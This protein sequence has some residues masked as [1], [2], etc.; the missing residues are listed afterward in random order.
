MDPFLLKMGK[1]A[2]AQNRVVEYLSW[3]PQL[4]WVATIPEGKRN[5]AAQKAWKLLGGKKYTPD[6]ILYEPR[7]GFCGLAIEL[8]AEGVVIYKEDG[9]LR[10]ND[11]IENQ[12][13]ILEQFRKRG[14]MAEFCIGSKEAID[15]INKYLK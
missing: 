13:K 8:K 11:H 9:K 6:I 2:Q 14:W 12:A 7:S 4:L 10:K 5:W 3:Y 1:E 15:L